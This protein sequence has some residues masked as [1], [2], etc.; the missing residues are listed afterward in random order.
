[1][2]DCS[3]ISDVDAECSHSVKVVTARSLH[4]KGCFPK[5]PWLNNLICQYE[6]LT[7]QY[8]PL[9]GKVSFLQTWLQGK[10]VQSKMVISPIELH[11]KMGASSHG[12]YVLAV[13][14]RF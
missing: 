10:I 4:C 3:S 2:S 11:P 1:M 14:E 6:A 13:T 9:G 5:S 12:K 7:D 8:L